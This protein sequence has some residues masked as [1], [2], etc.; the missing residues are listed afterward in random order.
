MAELPLVSIVTPSFN[1]A[2]YLEQAIQ[3]VLDQDYPNLEYFVIDGASSDKSTEILQKYS[4]RLNGWV[5]EPDQGQADAINK[6]FVRSS[7]EYIAWLNSDDFYLPGA[8]SAAIE[9]LQAHPDWG[10][11]YGDILAVDGRGDLINIQRFGDWGLEDLMQFRIIGQPAVF[12]RRSALKNAGLLDTRFHFLLDHQLWLRIAE[13]FP[14]GH[15]SRLLAVAR[16]H[17]GAKNVARAADFGK[18]AREVYLWMKDEP[19]MVK[20]FER[21]EKKILAGV[22]WI[23]G[24]YLSEAGQPWQALKENVK[25]LVLYPPTALRDWRRIL[26]TILQMAGLGLIKESYTRRRASRQIKSLSDDVIAY[27]QNLSKTRVE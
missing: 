18:D 21:S 7:G 15:I 19:G 17:E 23:N 24:R 3:S 27:L 12:M 1:Q 5:S 8:I 9:T 26:F 16:F 10:L 2:A 22:H 11:V 25:S 4:H 14:I 20:E 13:N 6:G